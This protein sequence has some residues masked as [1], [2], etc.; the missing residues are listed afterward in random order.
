[1]VTL[2]REP[3]AWAFW[4]ADH[5]HF[6]FILFASPLS[7]DIK[8]ILNHTCSLEQ[9]LSDGWGFLWRARRLI[10]EC[11]QPG[12]SQLRSGWKRRHAQQG[13]LID[14]LRNWAEN[15]DVLLKGCIEADPARVNAAGNARARHGYVVREFQPGLYED[16]TDEWNKSGMWE[17]AV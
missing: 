4:W 2:Q 17:M 11:L 8:F 16:G 1:M 10:C 14:Q 7:Q 13:F 15:L 12:N 3:E 5:L 9:R 6:S